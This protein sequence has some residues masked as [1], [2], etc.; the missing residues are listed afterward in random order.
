M[1]NEVNG[2]SNVASFGYGSPCI[3]HQCIISFLQCN[4][5]LGLN[6]MV[7]TLQQAAELVTAKN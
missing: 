4:N 2:T 6:L 5:Q 3:C 7:F 1:V